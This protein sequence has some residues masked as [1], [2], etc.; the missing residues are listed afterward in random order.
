MS[1]VL[2]APVQFGFYER[3]NFMQGKDGMRPTVPFALLGAG[4]RYHLPGGLAAG[5][6]FSWLPML[7][8][9]YRYGSDGGPSYKGRDLLVSFSLLLPVGEEVP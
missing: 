7:S 8:D 1:V 3:F 5:T 9:I 2:D 6:E 4:L